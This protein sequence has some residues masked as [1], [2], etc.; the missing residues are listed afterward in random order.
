MDILD[1][2]PKEQRELTKEQA[3][4]ITNIMRD[5]QNKF[6]SLNVYWE[7]LGDFWKKHGFPEWAEEF[8]ERAKN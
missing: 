5:L 4:E 1:E 2:F 7:N 8:Y 3:D 6:I